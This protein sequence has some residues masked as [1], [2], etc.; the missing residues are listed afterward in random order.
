MSAKDFE[1]VSPATISLRLLIRSLIQSI[2]A[3][4]GMSPAIKYMKK[5]MYKARG[6]SRVSITGKKKLAI[7]KA[8]PNVKKIAQT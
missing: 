7:K 6:V 4:L 1:G 3:R 8:T 5:I 2:S